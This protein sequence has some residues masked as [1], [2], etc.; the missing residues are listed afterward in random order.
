MPMNTTLDIRPGPPG[1]SPPA[2]ARARRDHLGHDLGRRQVAGQPGLAG[3]AERAGHPA[4]RLRRHAH[5]DPA[6]I[7]HEHRLDVARRRTRATVSCG[8]CPDRSE[9]ALG[10]QQ[11]GQQQPPASSA[12]A[13]GRQVGHLGRVIGQPGEVVPGQLVRAEARLTELRRRLAPAGRVQVGQ[14]PRRAN[15]GAG[16]AAAAAGRPLAGPAGRT[17]GR[18]CQRAV[19][20]ACDRTAVRASRARPRAADG[21]AGRHLNLPALGTCTPCR[22]VRR[23]TPGSRHCTPYNDVRA[24]YTDLRQVGRFRSHAELAQRAQDTRIAARPG[25]PAILLESESPY[26]QPACGRRV[27]RDDHRCLPA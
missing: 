25:R 6:R 3:R 27:R 7:A 17:G 13:A 19:G 9:L 2:S 15:G 24:P 1:T 23:T 26:A 21:V 18:A 10:G 20:R 14:V 11:L 8:S 12:R 4:A 22:A 5:R 16:D